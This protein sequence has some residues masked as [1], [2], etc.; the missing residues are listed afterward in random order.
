MAKNQNLVIDQLNAANEKIL[1][2]EEVNASQQVRMQQ[3]EDAAIDA[4]F[5][6]QTEICPAL[7]V[8]K[9]LSEQ[10]LAARQEV[11]R[12]ADVLDG[13]SL[14]DRLEKA[15]RA[16]NGIQGTAEKNVSRKLFKHKTKFSPR[17]GGKKPAPAFKSK[18]DEAYSAF[19]EAF[20]AI[21][22]DS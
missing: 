17:P 1:S 13:T 2:F 3:E 12:L 10:Q 16:Y 22:G 15:V 19:T 18:D 7:G 14:E 6:A 11:F 21:E 8:N 4:F 20:D 9:T 5:D